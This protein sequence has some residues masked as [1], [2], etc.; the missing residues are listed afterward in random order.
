MTF[1]FTAIMNFDKLASF[2]LKAVLRIF[3]PK[4]QGCRAP[5]QIKNKIL[6]DVQL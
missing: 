4:A 1:E 6:N 2:D 5:E 3:R